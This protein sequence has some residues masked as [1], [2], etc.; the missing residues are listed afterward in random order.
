[1]SEPLEPRYFD[2]NIERILQSWEVCHAIREL[3]A[4]AL[5]EQELTA[6]KEIEITK[7][8]RGQWHVRDYGRGLKYEHLTQNENAEKLNNQE[9]VIGKFGVGLK[10]S[11]ATLSRR[12]VTIQIRSRH[13]DML[14]ERA[15]K[16]SFD[17]IE[18]LHAVI[19]P[20]GDTDF[21]GTDI[22]LI[23]VGDSD[24][25]TAK[26]YFLRFSNEVVLDENRY[27]LIIQ[28][29]PKRKAGIYITGL[30]VA[31]EE[32]FAFS[33]N[34]TCLTS[35]ILRA[36]NRER[37]NAGRSAYSDRVKAMLLESKSAVV[38]GILAENLKQIEQG[39]NHDELSWKD[40]AVH[41]CRILNATGK[42][43]FVTG[44]QLVSMR[45]GV[46]SAISDGH[47]VICLPENVE[48]QIQSIKD[49]A[50]MP[51]RTLDV[52][53]RELSESF[54]FEFVEE[55]KMTRWEQDVFG[56]RNRIADLIGGMPRN[57]RG[58]KVSETM[59]PGNDILTPTNGVWEPQHG[60]I[61]IKRSMLASIESFAGALLHEFI[62]AKTAYNDMSADFETALTR[63][64]GEVSEHALGKKEGRGVGFA[65]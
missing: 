6:T 23:R 26:S 38:A 51:V 31:E 2:L 65:P 64:L 17:E 47:Q 28:R 37:S 24:M 61:I 45:E 1:M 52:Y 53:Q 60:W 54:E 20:A 13:C 63:A 11:L 43:I 7:D 15:P 18:T 16:H 5:D 29:D 27:G 39:S 12:R 34:I 59:R 49:L 21:Q 56:L 14:L 4:N 32:N 55:S 19:F 58:I 22:M 44:Q 48:R 33:Y 41:A 50:G 8:A 9:K 10:D 62:H 40:V 25:D 30:L 35:G 42:V 36:L 46:D 57:V 3:I